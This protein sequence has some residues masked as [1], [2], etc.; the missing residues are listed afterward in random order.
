MDWCFSVIRLEKNRENREKKKKKKDKMKK[1]KVSWL[2]TCKRY[3]DPRP[4][5]TDIDCSFVSCREERMLVMTVMLKT[6]KDLKR[7]K[8]LPMVKMEPKPQINQPRRQ[9]LKSQP[10][11]L[12]RLRA[13]GLEICHSQQPKQIWRLISQ[14]VVKLPVS[15]VPLAETLVRRIKGRFSTIDFHLPSYRSM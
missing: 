6:K 13:F 15:N 10:K 1:R 11:N 8:A 3:L 2:R 14:S 4:Y 9:R 7:E 12:R 5:V